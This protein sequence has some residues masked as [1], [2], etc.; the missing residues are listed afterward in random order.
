MRL[1]TRSRRQEQAPLSDH[2]PRPPGAG[3]PPPS[4]AID[5]VG[6]APPGLHARFSLTA[7]AGPA[8]DLRCVH[9]PI[10]ERF[11]GLYSVP[12]DAGAPGR[13]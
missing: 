7:E 2:A 10:D 4:P 6:G 13:A 9:V 12:L 5:V 1:I 8:V 11:L 3:G